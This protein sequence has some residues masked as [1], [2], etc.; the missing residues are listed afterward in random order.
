[1]D[2]CPICQ[3]SYAPSQQ[4]CRTR[5]KADG[6]SHGHSRGCGMF[7]ADMVVDDQTKQQ[8]RRREES[9]ERPFKYYMTNNMFDETKLY[10]ARGGG[11]AKKRRTVAQ[12]CQIAYQ[13]PARPGGP[14]P[15]HDKDIVRPPALVQ[16]CTAAA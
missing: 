14:L 9:L 2:W 11:R 6:A 16:H 10:V 7:T 5:S 1:M 3:S 15:I 12:A 8:K 13:K 4:P